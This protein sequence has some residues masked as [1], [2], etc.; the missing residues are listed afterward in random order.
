MGNRKQKK[1]YY[2]YYYYSWDMNKWLHCFSRVI[3]TG[4]QPSEDCYSIKECHCI[5]GPRLKTGASVITINKPMCFTDRNA[6]EHV[7]SQPKVYKRD[8]MIDEWLLADKPS[9]LVLLCVC[10]TSLILPHCLFFLTFFSI[11]F[12]VIFLWF[13]CP[14]SLSFVSFGNFFSI[15]HLTAT[16]KFKISFSSW[17]WMLLP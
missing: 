17:L 4:K 13:F 15:I 3:N 11:R 5:D 1:D 7:F 9:L 16:Y 6:T 8:L 2:C 10:W 12:E 14:L